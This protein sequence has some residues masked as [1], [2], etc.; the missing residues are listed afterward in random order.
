MKKF[1]L[2]WSV[3]GSMNTGR[4][5]HAATVLDNG[6][7]LVTGGATIEQSAIEQSELYDP[8][9][10]NWTTVDYMNIARSLHTSS[11]LPSDGPA[12]VSS[13]LRSLS[14]FRES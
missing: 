4:L 14:F 3:T 7:V 11:L 5:S 13:A 9:I 12:D 8:S 1:F 6:K 2:V 10:G